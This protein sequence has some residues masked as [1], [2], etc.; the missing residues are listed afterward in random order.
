MLPT[1]S[2]KGPLSPGMSRH[3]WRE[4]GSFPGNITVALGSVGFT[5]FS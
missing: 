3:Q 2:E 4:A 1:L 5:P